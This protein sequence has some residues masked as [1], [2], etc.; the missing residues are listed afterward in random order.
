MG[1]N[2][3][4]QMAQFVFTEVSRISKNDKEFRSLARSM[5]SILQVNGLGAA[6]AFL[7]SKKKR[8][9]AHE[10]MYQIMDK[11]FRDKKF[12]VT[13]ETKDLIERIV[14]LDSSTYRLYMSE[15]MKLCLWVKRFSEGW[16]DGETK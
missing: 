11:W 7:C 6:I 2:L 12:Q 10:L 1:G 9:N 14:N 5:P 13:G 15:M 4:N 16:I 8:G 3:H